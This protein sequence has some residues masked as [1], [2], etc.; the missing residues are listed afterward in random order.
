VEVKGGD[1][2]WRRSPLRQ[3]RYLNSIVEQD[4]RRIG[5]KDIQ[6]Q[7]RFVAGLFQIAASS[8]ALSPPLGSPSNALRTSQQKL[9]RPGIVAGTIRF[10]LG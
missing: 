1:E 3:A 4:H 10:W 6:A 2:P 5:G 7:S 9:G 8:A